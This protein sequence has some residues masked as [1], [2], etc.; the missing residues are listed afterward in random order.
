MM[1]AHIVFTSGIV[2]RFGVMVSNTVMF[3]SSSL[4]LFLGSLGWS[5]PLHGEVSPLI[6]TLVLYIGGATAAVF[7]LRYRSL[8]SLSPATVG[9]YHNLIPVCTVLLAYM[10]LDEPVGAK[11]IIGGVMV[12]AGAEVVRRAPF[13]SFSSRRYWVKPA[14]PKVENTTPIH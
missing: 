4:L 5:E 1:S 2:K 11:T 8:Q 7:M 9:T 3:G 14:L 12:V 10:C 13:L 6:T